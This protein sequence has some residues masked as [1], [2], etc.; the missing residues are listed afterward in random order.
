MLSKI[1]IRLLDLKFYRSNEPA[2]PIGVTEEFYYRTNQSRTYDLNE[3][4]KLWYAQ[5]IH[6]ELGR[7]ISDV[8][9]SSAD[10][11]WDY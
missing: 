6:Q 9:P 5:K 4:W 11:S 1:K 2:H 7:A 10:L 8:A 3:V